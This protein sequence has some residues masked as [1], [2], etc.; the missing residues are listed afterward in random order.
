MRLCTVNQVITALIKLMKCSFSST[1]LP[2]HC[3]RLYVQINVF[4]LLFLRV[5]SGS[6]FMVSFKRDVFADCLQRK[7]LVMPLIIKAIKLEILLQVPVIIDCIAIACTIVHNGWLCICCIGI[8]CEFPASAEWENCK[9]VEPTHCL[10]S[11]HYATR[12]AVRP[13]A[14]FQ[15]DLLG[16]QE[17]V[18]TTWL[19]KQ[20]LFILIEILVISVLIDELDE[21]HSRAL[22]VDDAFQ[23]KV[24]IMSGIAEMPR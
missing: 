21:A 7:S 8:R 14:P 2:V 13:F 23:P 12:I 5:L 9:F 10:K 6:V 11:T 20:L 3:M 16:D 19:D 1:F 22:V 18:N 4:F 17:A 15:G 24:A